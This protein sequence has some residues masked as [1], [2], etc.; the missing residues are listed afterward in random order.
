MRVYSIIILISISLFI[1]AC[2]VSEIRDY[3]AAQIGVDVTNDITPMNLDVSVDYDANILRVQFPEPMDMA[4]GY[5]ELYKDDDYNFVW[6][7]G[8]YFDC[9]AYWRYN[10]TMLEL[11]F[12]KEDV[13]RYLREIRVHDFVSLSNRLC[14]N[15]RIGVSAP[16]DGAGYH[17]RS[18]GNDLYI[19]F[20]SPLDISYRGTVYLARTNCMA[21]GFNEEYDVVPFGGYGYFF[22]DS[23]NVV[24][25]QDV[26]TNQYESLTVSGFMTTAHQEVEG[27]EAWISN[28]ETPVI[29]AITLNGIIGTNSMRIKPHSEIFYSLSPFAAQK[30]RHIRMTVSLTNI[31]QARV[32]FGLTTIEKR[33]T[34]FLTGDTI[35]A[36]I[37]I[38]HSV[39][40][41]AYNLSVIG[42]CLDTVITNEYIFAIDSV[43]NH[44]L[45]RSNRTNFLSIRAAGQDVRGYVVYTGSN[46][47]VSKMTWIEPASVVFTTNGIADYLYH[48]PA[49]MGETAR[50]YADSEGVNVSIKEGTEIKDYVQVNE[51]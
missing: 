43:T 28:L 38:P 50:F 16:R 25:L 42:T 23:S 33:D 10:D 49:R 13:L 39:N 15:T 47:T 36:D 44:I 30:Y 19:F 14:E 26:Y 46:G 22:L 29:S 4:T 34:V 5:I 27:G 3:E 8:T 51:D 35:S 18:A 37:L 21:D 7:E 11:Q 12:V 1:S 17:V 40:V 41:T 24:R 9:R 48:V 45:V 32:T 31:T 20:D 2:H 6:N